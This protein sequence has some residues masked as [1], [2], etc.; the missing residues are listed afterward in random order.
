MPGR[1]RAALHA[2]SLL[3][4]GCAAPGGVPADGEEVRRAGAGPLPT[5]HGAAGLTAM[6]SKDEQVQARIAEQA[7]EWFVANDQGPLDA[8]ESAALVAWLKASPR[9]IEEFL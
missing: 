6:T 8:E 9:H 4:R 1:G 3:P 5:P 7:T 2:W